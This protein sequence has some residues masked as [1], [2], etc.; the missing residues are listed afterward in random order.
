MVQ[1][2]ARYLTLPLTASMSKFMQE[3]PMTRS[4]TP[5]WGLGI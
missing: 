2:S 1:T 3:L 5:P 4:Y